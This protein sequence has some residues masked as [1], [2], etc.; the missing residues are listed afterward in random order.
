MRDVYAVIDGYVFLLRGQIVYES[1]WKYSLCLDHDD[2]Q[3]MILEY[4]QR[5]IKVKS[6]LKLSS[7]KKTKYPAI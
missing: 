3:L 7:K 6:S 4:F 1:R 2:G 5:N